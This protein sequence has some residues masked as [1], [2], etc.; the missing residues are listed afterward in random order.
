MANATRTQVPRDQAMPPPV[1]S[2]PSSMVP[3]DP[4]EQE[5]RTR[6]LRLWVQLEME[7]ASWR[8]THQDII[9]FIQP[10]HGQFYQHETNK[11]TRKDVKVI[12]NTAGE[13][14]RKLGAAIDTGAFSEARE[15]WVA[16]LEDATDQEDERNP[17]YC[18][19]FQE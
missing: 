3:A 12:N 2:E 9:D 13:R 14:I 19:A 5:K 6:L 11:G 16:T 18:H 8:V 7:Y 1:P 15:W 17:E 4:K 10:N